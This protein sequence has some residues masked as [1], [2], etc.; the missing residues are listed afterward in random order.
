VHTLLVFPILYYNASCGH[1]RGSVHGV[2]VGG[3]V[4]HD[5]GTR[6][7]TRNCVLDGRSRFLM[8][9]GN[10]EGKRGDPLDGGLM[11]VQCL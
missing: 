5:R 7:G 1:R 9:M 6:L 4:C 10:F 11:I 8:R 3:S 2:S